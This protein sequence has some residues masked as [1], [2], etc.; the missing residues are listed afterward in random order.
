ML[1]QSSK[2]KAV[3]PGGRA[4]GACPHTLQPRRP[5]LQQQGEQTKGEGE[6]RNGVEKGG[7]WKA[8]IGQGQSF[9]LSEPSAPLRSGQRVRGQIFTFLQAGKGEL[10]W[11]RGW[12]RK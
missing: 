11:V 9:E 2:E 5:Q 1:L 7:G 10:G 3:C 6:G 12:E 8:P 4:P